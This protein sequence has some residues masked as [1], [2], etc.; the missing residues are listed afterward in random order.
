MRT[1]RRRPAS[2][3]RSATSAST[4]R[5]TRPPTRAIVKAGVLGDV[6]HARLVWHRNGT[7]R[8]KEEPPVA[9]LRP[10]ALGLP[11]LR[12]PD[13]LAPLLEVLARPHGRAGEPPGERREL[14]LRGHARGRA[15]LGRGLP[16]EERGP[17]GPGPRLRDLRVPAGPHRRLHLDRVER[18]TTTT[19]R[20]TTAPRR[21]LI[22]RGE[23][24]AYLFDEGGE[25][26]ATTI[27]V[28]GQGQGRPG[29]RRLGEPGR[30]RGRA[31][32]A[33]RRP[34]GR[35]PAGAPTATRCRSSAPPS[36]PARRC[37]AV[38]RRPSAR[39]SPA[40]PATRPWRR[41]PG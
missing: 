11:D 15:R 13:Q 12:P 31:V 8:R 16:L 27:E 23:T 5:S 29:D 6:Y 24:E 3:S 28:G 10:L 33:G 21:T 32:A 7:W 17:R 39:R 30:R 9:G 19:T 14:V 36:A 22:L 18:L 26:K 1:R 38:P 2:C 20:P 40:S 25:K 34:A 37:A 35:R 41:R 4:T